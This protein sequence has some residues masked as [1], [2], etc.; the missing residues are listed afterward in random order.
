MQIG[1][2]DSHDTRGLD[3]RCPGA[4]SAHVALFTTSHHCGRI[5]VASA[6]EPDG[7]WPTQFTC[8]CSA[9]PQR[10]LYHLGDSPD[11]CARMGP[12]LPFIVLCLSAAVPHRVKAADGEEPTSPGPCHPNP[13]H[14]RGTCEI[15]ETYRGDTFIGYVCKC[16]QGFSGVHCQHNINECEKDPCKNGGICTDQV[17][18]YSCECPGEYMGRNCQYSK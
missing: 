11:C 13:C 9:Q 1:S 17:A 18:N 10:R 6:E 3:G 16:P 5:G 2:S 14:N 8:S 15:S 4:R 12:L 7:R